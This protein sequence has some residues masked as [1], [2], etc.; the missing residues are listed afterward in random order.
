MRLIPI[1]VAAALL[2]AN[3][4]ASSATSSAAASDSR[5]CTPAQGTTGLTIEQAIARAEALGYAV[6]E[7]K[8]SKGCWEIEGYDRNGAEIEIVIDPVS[9]EPVKAKGWLMPA[10]R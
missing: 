7:A 6:K 5:R 2:A 4:A 1:A 8:R 9:G 3:F 10:A